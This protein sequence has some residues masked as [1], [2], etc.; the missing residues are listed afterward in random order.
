M[1]E[2]EKL[3]KLIRLKRFESPPPDF[4]D[5]FVSRL[6][7]RE[8][9]E[10]LRHSSSA[11]FLEQIKVWMDQIFAP[12]WVL[13]TAAVL[14]VALSTWRLLPGNPR[15]KPYHGKARSVSL[16][17]DGTGAAIPAYSVEAIRVMGASVQPDPGLLSRH[18]QGTRTRH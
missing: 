5:G 8:R 7:Q 6:R 12:K 17:I 14:V 1:E 9:K 3:Q 2:F 10:M 11:F 18:F 13:T 15:N 4:V 16:A